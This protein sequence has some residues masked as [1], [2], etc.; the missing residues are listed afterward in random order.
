MNLEVVWN[1]TYLVDDDF[2]TEGGS[3][4]LIPVLTSNSCTQRGTTTDRGSFLCSDGVQVRR[5]G[6]GLQHLRQRR[7]D[8]AQV[9]LRVVRPF[10]SVQLRRAVVH[11]SRAHP[12]QCEQHTHTQHTHTEVTDIYTH[13]HTHTRHYSEL[14]N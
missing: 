14:R 3:L 12:H 1:G 6:S 4:L 9:P 2:A 10:V 7:D 8:E 13:T 5:H 11:V